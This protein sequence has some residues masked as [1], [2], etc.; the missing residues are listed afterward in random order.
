MKQLRQYTAIIE[1]EGEGYVSLCP[2]LDIASQGDTVEEARR[3]LA[4]ALE[5]FFEAAD[6]S[7]VQSRLRSEVFVTRVEVA[8]G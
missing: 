4:E 8:V 2:E 7:E 5:L 1:G 3:N 6:P